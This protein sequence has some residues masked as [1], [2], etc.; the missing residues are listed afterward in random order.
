MTDPVAPV[1]DPASAGDELLRG[2]SRHLQSL[3]MKDSLLSTGTQQRTETVSLPLVPFARVVKIG[4]R[5]IDGGSETLLPVV[6]ELRAALAHSK[7]IIGAGSG[8]RSRHVFSVGLDLGLPTGVLAALSATDAEQNAHILGALLAR[9]GVVSLPP[10][11]VTHIL[12]AL[13]V[14]G[15]GVVVNGVPP[16]ELWEHPPSIGRIPA[17]RTD[18]GMYLLAEIYG[19]ERAILVKD[20]DGLFSADPTTDPDATHVPHITVED[21][22]SSRPETL[23]FDELLLELMPH[24]HHCREV[25]I[26]DGTQPGMLTRALAGE[27]VGSIIEAAGRRSGT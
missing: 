13:L 14:L 11:L 1:A 8:I 16:F 12:P 15:N 4:G 24:G 18:V 3:L 23:P 2:G 19:V 20:V 10:P 17:N 21:L 27:P 7:L 22:V 5:I 6:D 26:V 25:Q 9:D